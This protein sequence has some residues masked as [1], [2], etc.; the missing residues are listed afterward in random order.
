MMTKASYKLGV[1]VSAASLAMGLQAGA[2]TADWNK[3]A[4]G[5]YNW[6][7]CHGREVIQVLCGAAAW[8]QTNG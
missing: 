6:K 3:T 1:A 4:P 8:S 7:L 2:A 5:L